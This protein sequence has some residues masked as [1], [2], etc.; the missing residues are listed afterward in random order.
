MTVRIAINGFGRMGRLA[1]RAAWGADPDRPAGSWGKGDVAVV[2]INEPNCDAE[3]SAHLLA[4]DS[5]HGR[6][7]VPTAARDG[8][9]LIAQERLG[10]TRAA[11]PAEI[12][13]DALGIDI[14]LECSGKFKTM[15]KAAPYFESGVSKVVVSAPVKKD[16]LNIVMGVNDHL[17]DPETHHLITAASCTTNCLA[18]IVKVVHEGIGI[19]Q[20]RKST[21]LNSSH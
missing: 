11:S 3:M 10:Y 20:D 18:P 16:A 12:D 17:Y 1:L 19:R 9:I 2:H 15:E 8:E 21:R 5:V 13:W 7:P 4:F 14:V 6:W